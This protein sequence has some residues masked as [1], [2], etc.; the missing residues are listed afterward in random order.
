MMKA[1]FKIKSEYIFSSCNKGTSL[2]CDVLF[3]CDPERNTECK[4]TF[5]G[6][7]KMT[8]NIEFAKRFDPYE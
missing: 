4:K 2:R 5:C 3:V 7:C 8:S 1:N 6:E